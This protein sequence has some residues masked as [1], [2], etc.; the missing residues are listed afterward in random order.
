MGLLERETRKK[1][2]DLLRDLPDQD[3]PKRRQLLLRNIPRDIRD[4]IVSEGGP[5][6][7]FTNIILTVDNEAWEQP[8]V[9][10]WPILTLIDNAVAWAE[11]YK[12]TTE[13]IITTLQGMRKDLQEEVVLRI[14][15]FAQQLE[16]GLLSAFPTYHKLRNFV[17]FAL[18]EHLATFAATGNLSIAVYDLVLWARMKKRLF[19][20]VAAAL[21]ENPHDP[22]LLTFA[23]QVGL[24]QN[25]TPYTPGT[26]FT[27]RQIRLLSLALVHTFTYTEFQQIALQVFDKRLECIT[28]RPDLQGISIDM[29]LYSEQYGRSG[30]LLNAAL[31]LQPTN[32][33][34]RAFMGLPLVEPPDTIK[35]NPVEG[36]QIGYQQR[37]VLSKAF[38]RLFSYA[39]LQNLV[40]HTLHKE[41]DFISLGDNLGVIIGDLIQ[42]AEMSGVL[43][44][45]VEAARIM[46]PDDPTLL[47]FPNLLEDE[48]DKQVDILLGREHEKQLFNALVNAFSYTEIRSLVARTF[49]TNLE[50]ISLASDL[51]S[52]VFKLIIWC[53]N[54]RRITKLVIAAIAVRP[55]D[56]VLRKIAAEIAA[57]RIS[58]NAPAHQNYAEWDAARDDSQDLQ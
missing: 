43:V 55:K 56:S 21:D 50:I 30:E 20:L 23:V 4:A 18:N 22:Y 14:P 35:S 12:P 32:P 7:H 54:S 5:T 26:T 3:D 11:L 34:L 53:S 51:E 38:E 25:L 2:V 47:F 48:S 33:P 10:R 46:K 37:R 29:V 16:E 1:L 52:V 57:Q 58:E 6:I 41:L 44:R 40:L 24:A 15:S 27:G 45:L 8:L 39:E 19:E 13:V 36:L 42:W 9:G 28:L 31:V 49:A 17:L